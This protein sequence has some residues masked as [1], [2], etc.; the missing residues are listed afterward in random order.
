MGPLAIGMLLGGGLGLLQ[1]ARNESKEKQ[2]EA[3][4]RAALQWSPWTG[5]QDPGALNLPGVLE[6]TVGGVAKGAMYGDVYSSMAQKM[7]ERAQE[8]ALQEAMKY[9]G[10][11][12]LGGNQSRNLLSPY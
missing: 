1:G 6:S 8:Q 2:Q 4:R 7:A 10:G 5:M 3:F 12:T 9:S 11:S